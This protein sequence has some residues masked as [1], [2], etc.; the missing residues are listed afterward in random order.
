MP[1][2]KNLLWCWLTGH[3]DGK[4][5][6]SLPGTDTAVYRCGRCG[7][8]VPEDKMGS[9]ASMPPTGI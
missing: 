9:F 3:K 6:G 1:S 7:V 4:Y 8:L 2:L 5:V